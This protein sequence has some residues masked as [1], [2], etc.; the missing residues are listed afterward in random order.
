MIGLLGDPG[1]CQVMLVTLPEETPVNEAAET[2]FHL[3]DRAGVQLAPIVVNGL[4]PHL[5]LPM[6]T[7]RAIGAT[8]LA[9]P[10]RPTSPAWTEPPHSAG[11]AR[12]LQEAQ[13]SRLADAAA[14][15]AAAPAVPLHHR[16]RTSRTSRPSPTPWAPS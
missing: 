10:P 3:E 9:S 2:A 7:A 11:S 13:V 4:W 12:H 6:D 5:D 15:A 16:A 1:R 8:G 14:V